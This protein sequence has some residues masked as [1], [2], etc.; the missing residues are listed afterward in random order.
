MYEYF[1]CPLDSMLV[2]EWRVTLNMSF[3]AILLY[4]FI[5][6]E[7]GTVSVTCLVQEHNVR[8]RARA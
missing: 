8:I 4:M 6:V 1:Y 5:W 3:A 7:R 2:Y